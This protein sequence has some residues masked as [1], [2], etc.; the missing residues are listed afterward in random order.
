MEDKDLIEKIEK[1]LAGEMS[2]EEKIAFE[3]QRNNSSEINQKVIAH[4]LF[5]DQLQSY[6]ARRSFIQITKAAFS[7]LKEAGTW[8]N[9]NDISSNDISSTTKVIQLW[10]KYKKVTAIAASVGGVIAL[11]TSIL[12]MS[13]S[14]RLN[15]N[16]L[17]QLSKDIEV[18]KKKSTGTRSLN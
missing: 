16:Q 18:I 4:K 3:S 13:L 9:T 15:G 5:L 2:S 8:H 17:L 7:K 11:T 6:A 1:Y 14:P 12:V 10:N